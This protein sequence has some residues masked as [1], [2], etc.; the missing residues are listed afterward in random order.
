MR[1]I[2]SLLREF[3]APVKINHEYNDESLQLLF[4]HD[5]ELFNRWEAGQRYAIRLLLKLIKDFHGNLEW[6][7]PADY[8]ATLQ[9][10]LQT[11]QKDKLLLAEMLTLPAEKYLGEQMTMIDVDAIHYVREY[12]LK[13][14]AL[15]LKD[16]FIDLYQRNNS[17]SHPYHFDLNAVSQRSITNCCLTYLSLLDDTTIFDSIIFPHFKKALNHNMTDT[18]NALRCIVNSN[19]SKRD[20]ALESFYQKWQNDAL[21]LDKWFMLQATAKLKDTLFNVKNLLKHPAFDIKNPNKVY[22]LLGAFGHRNLICS[23]QRMGQAMNFSQL[24]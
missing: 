15:K 24:C 17:L 14:I 16:V 3:S 13:E 10:L 7:V 11:M 2:P 4:K 20:A 19:F 12:V 18:I 23:M 1:P 8:I 6:Q 22:S 9:H 21:V 5:P